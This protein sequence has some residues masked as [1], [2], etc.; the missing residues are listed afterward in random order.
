MNYSAESLWHCP[1][2]DHFWYTVRVTLAVGV[3]FAVVYGGADWIAQQHSLR[4]RVH[5][6]ADLLVPFVPVSVLGYL[7]IYPLFAFASFILRT[8]REVR[9][10]GVTMFSVIAV[11]GVGF[12][13]IPAQSAFPPASEST[14][15]DGLVQF[16]KRVAL[17]NNYVPSLH[18]ALSVV[19]V[20]LYARRAR[21]FGR[22]VWWAWSL[23]IAGSTVLL[24]Q[25]YLVDV[26][27][28]YGLGLAGVWW[29]YDRCAAE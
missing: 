22:I 19:C 11:G 8:H 28:G 15:W 13:L 10:L 9:A 21:L 5:S 25:H 12:L 14:A 27:T 24:H 20:C 1:T 4:V 16:A 23:V 17:E 3:W 2:W 6:G 29:V 7:S 18:V 26:L